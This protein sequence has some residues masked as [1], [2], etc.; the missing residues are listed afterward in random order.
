MTSVNQDLLDILRLLEEG[1]GEAE[2]V[3]VMEQPMRTGPEVTAANPVCGMGAYSKRMMK[4]A[5]TSSHSSTRARRDRKVRQ[6]RRR[7]NVM[8][9]DLVM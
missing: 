9:Y 3:M 7:T 2:T 5:C 8:I 1:S 4:K 6:V